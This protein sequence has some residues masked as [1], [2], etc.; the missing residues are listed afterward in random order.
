[1]KTHRNHDTTIKQDSLVL[2]IIYCLKK[3]KEVNE[4]SEMPHVAH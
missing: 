4:E 1:M 3:L 2:Q